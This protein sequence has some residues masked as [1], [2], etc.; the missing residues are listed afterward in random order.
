MDEPS[1]MLKGKIDISFA[2][3]QIGYV[4]IILTNFN[5]TNQDLATCSGTN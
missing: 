5:L 3:N 4:V 2:N 1:T